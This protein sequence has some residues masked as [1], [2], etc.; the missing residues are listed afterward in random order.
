[1]RAK[2]LSTVLLSVALLLAFLQVGA[3]PASALEVNVSGQMVF[4]WGF[5]DNYSPDA[6][7]QFWR[8]YG[9]ETPSDHF[10]ARQR[11]RFQA[12]FVAS[13]NLKGV[14]QVQ[15]GTIDWG[16]SGSGGALDTT[17]AEGKVRR[18][19]I[20]FMLPESTVNVKM[21]LQEIALPS[22]VAGNPI[23]DSHVASVMLSAGLSDEITLTGFW[24]RPYRDTGDAARHKY[25]NNDMDMFGL[26]ADFNY[27]SVVFQPYLM[28]S[29][30][31]DWSGFRRTIGTERP[32][33]DN[34]SDYYLAGLAL[35][36]KP[37]DRLSIGFD[38]LYNY[39]ENQAGV[40]HDPSS[41]EDYKYFDKSSGWFAA[42]GVDYAFD[43]ATLSLVAWYASGND[44]DDLSKNKT[45]RGAILPISNNVTGFAPARL[46]FKGAYAIGDDSLISSSGASTW[47][48][49]LHLKDFS[50]VEDLS[51]TARLVYFQ[52]TS[53]RKFTT[54]KGGLSILD[55]TTRDK[56]FEIDF[57]ST[58][59]IYEG[60]KAI[61]EMAYI[62]LDFKDRWDGLYRVPDNLWNVQF[63][64]EYS[65]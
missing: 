12:E 42:L 62:Q 25:K 5:R 18:A 13:E 64:L 48:L 3:R 51:H 26:L 56:A 32:T 44:Y 53:D 24:A 63:T 34:Y 59:Q 38:A 47:G 33:H 21:G 55:M 7:D 40:G 61:V 1:M 28:Y 52:G 54:V 43:F 58:Y 45:E 20:D 41:G 30:I 17:S 14:I 36:V 39:V 46:A 8:R 6:A 65:F 2:R 15:F 23:L 60:L 35:Q 22:A 31:G 9:E 16:D 27:D 10:F 11:A 19:Y 29:R 4:Q 50:F 49:G 37:T 57:D